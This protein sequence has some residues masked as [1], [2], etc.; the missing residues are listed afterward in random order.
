[1]RVLVTGASGLIG[2][3]VSA[4]LRA[5]G[6]EVVPLVRPRPGAAPAEASATW[7]PAAGTIDLSRAGRLD[8]AVHLAGESILGLWTAA[9]QARI[10]DSR[11]RGTRLLARALSRL[12]PAPSVLVSASAI[13]Y[14]GD[15]G[16]EPLR[17]DSPPGAGF[18]AEVCREWE[19]AA[20]EA[21]DHLRV[22]RLRIGI[23]LAPQGGALRV[24]LPAFRAGVGGILG[25]GRQWMSWIAL[26]DLVAVIQRALADGTY[27]G[28]INAVSPQ[29]VTNADFTATLGRVLRRPTILP[30]PAFALKAVAGQMAQEMLLASTRV[31]SRRLHALG[32]A[33][34]DPELEPALRG[35]LR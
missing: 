20:E 27:A 7:D 33:F 30:V 18:L 21:S 34:Q 12:I 16:E 19:A 6:H 32:F 14:Y 10:R 4:A 29:P 5:D 13:G 25:S 8:G 22:V 2:S 31:E 26:P 17:E 28:A 35:L 1:M 15:R 3:A 9:K 23:V 11:L 24:M